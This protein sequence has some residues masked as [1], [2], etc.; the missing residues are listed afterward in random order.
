MSPPGAPRFSLSARPLLFGL[1]MTMLF[2]SGCGG[3]PRF[4]AEIAASLRRETMRRM[5]GPS[6]ILYYPERRKAQAQRTLAQLERCSWI[7]R[8]L[9]A[10]P[11][12]RKVPIV[13]PELP[14]NNAH[15]APGFAGVETNAVVPTFF[16]NDFLELGLAP[17]PGIV[18]CHEVVHAMQAEEVHGFQS[19]LF[20]VFGDAA[21]PQIG[22]DAWFWEG[23]AVHYEARM[24]PGVGR[25]ASPL[26]RGMFAAGVAGRHI[27]GGDLAAQQR[28][29]F[30]GSHYLFGGAFIDFLAQRYGEEKIWR[31]VDVQSRSIFVPFGVNVRFWQAY[32]KSLSTLLDEFD[33]H[34]ALN[35]PV[36]PRPAEQRQ[37]R[38][39]GVH[40]RWAAGRDGTQAFISSDLDDVLR[41][42]VLHPNGHTLL[43]RKLNEVLPPRRLREMG[44]SDISGLSVS[45]DGRWVVFVAVQPG[46]VQN[47]SRLV[48][49]NVANQT[50]SVAQGDLAGIGAQL[51]PDG[52]RYLFI[53]PDGDRHDLVE[54]VLASGVERVLVSGLPRSYF[55]GVR[56]SPRGDRLAASVFESNAFRVWI[57]D[58]KTGARLQ[59][60]S[61]SPGRQWEPFWVDDDRLVYE[62]EVDARQQI[63][64]ADL[65]SGSVSAL[66]NA[67]YA[68]ARPQSIDGRV[69]FLNR[70]G[71]RWTLDEV[72]IPKALPV[73]N[74]PGLAAAPFTH[75]PVAAQAS[76]LRR[77]KPELSDEP[78]SSVDH[79]FYL[80]SR[81][82]SFV[83]IGRG[84]VLLGLSLNGGDRLGNHA[85]AINGLYQLQT[86]LLSG[87]LGYA[88]MQLAPFV[89]GLGV[90]Q[91]RYRESSGPNTGTNLEH[92]QRVASASVSRAFWG[93]P[94]SLGFSYTELFRTA[95]PLGAP[96][97]V[98]LAGPIL[99]AAFI[100][101]DGS[102]YAGANRVLV[103]AGRA[104]ALPRALSSLPFSMVD[105]GAQVL[106]FSPLPLS[107]RHTLRL[108]LRGRELAG[109]NLPFLQVGGLLAAA[110][111]HEVPGTGTLESPLLPPGVSFSEAL[112]GFE[113]YPLLGRRAGIASL[114]YRYP[115]ILDVG[116]ASTLW[117]LPALFLH[118]IN[119]ELFGVAAQVDSGP[120]HQAAGAALSLNLSLWR[121]PLSVQYQVAK[122]LTD[123]ERVLHLLMLGGQ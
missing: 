9:I 121:I 56:Y 25:H 116:A 21:T 106:V 108:D 72:P 89:L 28:V 71:W 47:E 42:T 31:L 85:W 17:D 44:V 83:G 87:S 117:L 82:P 12:R 75:V 94:V 123:D 27:N 5:E 95:P 13:M 112:R 52:R 86:E 113:D 18:G 98:K 122:R 33:E 115:I 73:S 49:V 67:P 96:A 4:S 26:W 99:A 103:L 63:M 79:L 22:L 68:A 53:R 41:L 39:L 100:G 20:D 57:L 81:S 64:L 105:V 50:L 70:S 30:A 97:T 8:G 48:M 88:N 54:R 3:Q 114:T 38:A 16:T 110:P 66:T 2:A 32:G 45:N 120:L 119:F 34:L 10:K 104:H 11:Q 60:V 65:R 7:L 46:V 93:N 55:G 92:R 101:S 1:A 40:A 69:R 15:V 76:I 80:Q 35:Y 29:F 102:P 14:Y 62:G 118:Q 90:S 36:R 77:R 59:P 109:S 111:F 61:T 37:V 23:V 19:F 78:A 6:L 43:Q 84:P 91:L 58:S 51:S 74:P 107:R 24:L